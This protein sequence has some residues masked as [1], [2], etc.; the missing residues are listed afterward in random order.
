MTETR[1]VWHVERNGQVFTVLRYREHDIGW[2]EG[3]CLYY[4][5]PNLSETDFAFRNLAAQRHGGRFIY[6]DERM[7][8]QE[9]EELMRDK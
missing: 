9:A 6:L 2:T 8:W 7:T 1:R 5:R 4:G 3:T